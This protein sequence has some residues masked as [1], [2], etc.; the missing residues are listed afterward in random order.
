M[1][2]MSKFQH[3]IKVSSE[4]PS[5]MILFFHLEILQAIYGRVYTLNQLDSMTLVLS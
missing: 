2:C 3:F 1:I 5:F 4:F